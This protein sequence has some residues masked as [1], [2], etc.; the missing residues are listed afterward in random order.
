MTD[1]GGNVPTERQGGLRQALGMEL[2][3]ASPRLLL[4]LLVVLV[5]LWLG[6]P[7]AAL[8]DRSTKIG[9]GPV[10]VEAAQ[11]TLRKAKVS[12]ETAAQFDQ[13]Q[14]EKLT[15]LYT[16]TLEI[17]PKPHL[18]WVDD[19]PANNR[20]LVDFLELMGV[21]VQVAR[22]TQ[23]ALLR[24]EERSYQALV[25]DYSRPGDP[26]EQPEGSGPDWGAGARLA[27]VLQKRSCG[28]KVLLF[29]S[30]STDDRSIPPGVRSA[31]DNFYELLVDL[32]YALREPGP[33]CY[34][35]GSGASPAAP[36]APATNL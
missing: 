8:L 22:S 10:S 13:A 9:I 34:V 32:A 19:Q 6:E 16:D 21:S 14:V 36:S 35:D 15:Q 7:I 23:E 30:G 28:R 25:S 29:S 4:G 33:P 11:A 12:K 5:V 24:M 26:S 18:L 20:E 2:I 31:T 17:T 3:K 27:D 1:D